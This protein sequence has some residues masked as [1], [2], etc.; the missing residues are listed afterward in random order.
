MKL[1]TQYEG[2]FE[3]AIPEIEAGKAQVDPMLDDPHDDRFGLALIIPPS[4]EVTE[5]I[6]KFL[7][8]LNVIEPAQYPYPPAQIHVTVL[9]II[10]CVEGFQLGDIPVPQYL[11]TLERSL[12]EIDSFEIDYRGITASRSSIMIQ[13]FPKDETL[14]LLRERLRVNFLSSGLHQTMDARYKLSTAHATVFR[15]RKPLKD[16]HGFA[17]FLRDNRNRDFG[18]QKVSELQLVYN[19]WYH[20]PEKSTTLATFELP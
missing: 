16:S 20:R 7:S 6:K 15:F 10:S 2:L 9:S 8:E 17:A 14:E 13:G 18:G 5:K 12:A 3:K 4:R 1:L 19:D 11:A